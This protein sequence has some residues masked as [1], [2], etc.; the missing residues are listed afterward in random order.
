MSESVVPGP[1]SIQSFLKFGYFIEYSAERCPIDYSRIDRAPYVKLPRE[2]LLRQGAAKLRETFGQL[3]RAGREHVVPISGGLDSRLILCA[4]LEHTEARNIHTYTYGIPGCYDYEIGTH[5]AKVAGTRHMAFPM[6][7]ITY[8]RDELVEVAKRADCQAVLF[9]N[10]PLMAVE[11]LFGGGL[12][13]SGYVGDAVAGSYLSAEPSTTLLEAKRRHL[14]K[15]RLVTSWRLNQV[16]DE[17]F[18]PHMAGGRLAP[19]QL[20]WDE[21]V[22]FDEAVAKFTVAHV[23][24][25]GFDYVT[26]LINS[27]W[28]DFMFSVP[29]VFRLDT[30]LMI[31]IGRRTFPRLFQLPSKN[32][33]G[34][35]FDAP[36]LALKAT[37]WVNRARK[38]AHQ[39]VPNVVNWPN[40][41][42]NDFNEAIRTSPDVRGIVRDAID[43][44]RRRGLCDWVDFDGIWQRHERRLRNHADALIVLASLEL[45]IQAREE[46]QRASAS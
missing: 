6:N 27:P 45:L 43:A 7:R 14:G 10:Q 34:H 32:R 35:D 1:I 39:F 36:E 12:F 30:Q 28:M 19:E 8:H 16:D 33:I 44:L 29:N 38:L 21:Q 20:T 25:K 26:P 2:E 13:W 46:R 41:Q 40:S 18:V 3:F 23:L 15:R 24:W 42:Y 4:L 11:R 9:Y 17:A 22:L 31:D 37:F 5:V